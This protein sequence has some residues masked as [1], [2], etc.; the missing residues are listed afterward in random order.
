MTQ[1]LAARMFPHA[2]LHSEED[3][4]R[5]CCAEPYFHKSHASTPAR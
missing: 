3:D 4:D 2:R 5:Q 1:N